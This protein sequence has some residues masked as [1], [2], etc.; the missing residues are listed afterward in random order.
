MLEFVNSKLRDCL[1][2]VLIVELDEFC[3]TAEELVLIIIFDL[4]VACGDLIRVI[5]IPEEFLDTLVVVQIFL[6]LLDN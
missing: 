5:V 4:L 3:E 6:D 2:Q 1:S